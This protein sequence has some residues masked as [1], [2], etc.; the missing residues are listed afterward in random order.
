M[1]ITHEGKEFHWNRT[2][3]GER[4]PFQ[5]KVYVEGYRLS[6][7]VWLYD[8]INFLTLEEALAFYISLHISN[9]EEQASILDFASST[10]YN[11]WYGL[12]LEYM[13]VYENTPEKTFKWELDTKPGRA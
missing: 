3:V 7:E 13:E 8:T 2:E 4:P 11:G 5:V 1:K 9:R 10:K 12:T 6:K